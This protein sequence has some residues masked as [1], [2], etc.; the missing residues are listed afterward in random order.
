MTL[1]W[2]LDSQT[3]TSLWKSSC[4]THSK[5]HSPFHVKVVQKE[6]EGTGWRQWRSHNASGDTPRQQCA[7]T[8]HWLLRASSPSQHALL[9]PGQNRTFHSSSTLPWALKGGIEVWRIHLFASLSWFTWSSV[10]FIVDVPPQMTWAVEVHG[11]E[12]LYLDMQ[13]HSDFSVPLQFTL[14]SIPRCPVLLVLVV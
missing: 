1:C 10:M 6:H 14:S 7:S 13:C 2:P 12:S 4:R 3:V 8:S 11:T 5:F 9:P